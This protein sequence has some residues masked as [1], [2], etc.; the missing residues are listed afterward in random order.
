VDLFR[1]RRRSSRRFPKLHKH[2]DLRSVTRIQSKASPGAYSAYGSNNLTCLLFF[3][4][5]DVLCITYR[6]LLVVG[7]RLHG[8]TL[9]YI[10]LL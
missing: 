9:L 6:V 3:T 2:Q 4:A 10:T 1:R 7:D 5:C 8:S